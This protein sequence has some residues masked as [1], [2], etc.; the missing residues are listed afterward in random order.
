MVVKASYGSKGGCSSLLM[1]RGSVGSWDGIIRMLVQLKNYGLVLQSFCLIR[2]GDGRV[3][4]FWLDVWKGD[5]PLVISFHRIFSLD[6][7]I[8][9]L[10][11]D[12]MLFGWNTD[13]LRRIPRGDIKQTQWDALT[14]L[15][16][17]FQL[18]SS[19]GPFGVEY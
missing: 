14:S 10:V 5:A 6:T 11:G 15:I 19:P 1:R 4:S 8:L 7:H 3:T 16:E 13:S 17:D 18:Q 9:A 12:R 2:I